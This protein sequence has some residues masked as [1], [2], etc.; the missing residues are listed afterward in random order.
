MT[1]LNNQRQCARITGL[2]CTQVQVLSRRVEEAKLP[3]K[4]SALSQ[5]LFLLLWLRQYVTD[6]V[7]EWICAIPRSTFQLYRYVSACRLFF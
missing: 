1:L 6:A 5:T 4:I 2:S 3:W 7:L